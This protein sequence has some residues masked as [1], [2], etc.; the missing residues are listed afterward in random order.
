MKAIK[1]SQP[2][3]I[4]H[5]FLVNFFFYATVVICAIVA[6]FTLFMFFFVG[7][8][9]AMDI[10]GVVKNVFGIVP[11]LEGF[12]L[13]GIA[14]TV[15]SFGKIAAKLL[16]VFLEIMNGDAPRMHIRHFVLLA[17]SIGVGV[18][19][20]LTRNALAYFEKKAKTYLL[21]FSFVFFEYFA[22]I[23]WL[24]FGLVFKEVDYTIIL[25]FALVMAVVAGLVALLN[26]FYYKKRNSLF[27]FNC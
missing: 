15:A 26:Y 7:F 27:E 5:K 6:L 2:S 13:G 1:S 10:D 23:V 19:A 11:A 9:K 8:Y 12:G 25:G 18:V 20:I 14:E 3:L 24:Y 21:A 17:V 16:A 22:V 4:W